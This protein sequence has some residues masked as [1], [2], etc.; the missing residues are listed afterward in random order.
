MRKRLVWLLVLCGAMCF[1]GL[2]QV[3][4]GRSEKFPAR[5]FQD[6]D[7]VLAHYVSAGWVLVDPPSL[8]GPYREGPGAHQ[9][10][11]GKSKGSG[12]FRNAAGASVSYRYESLPDADLLII[13]LEAFDG[14]LTTVVVK[15][16]L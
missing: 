2:Y 13:G 15:K 9:V 7:H 8:P 5:P 14:R 10:G 3:Q 16:P 12:T 4:V 1:A 11:Q 6:L